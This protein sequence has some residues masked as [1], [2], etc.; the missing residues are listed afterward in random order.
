MTHETTLTVPLLLQWCTKNHQNIKQAQMGGKKRC[1]SGKYHFTG[2]KLSQK[3]WSLVCVCGHVC[4]C[5]PNGCATKKSK[6]AS[7]QRLLI[8]IW[9][10]GVYSWLPWEDRNYAL[11]EGRWQS[12]KKRDRWGGRVRA[13]ETFNE[14]KR[15]LERENQKVR[16]LQGQEME[17]GNTKTQKE[18]FYSRTGVCVCA[19]QSM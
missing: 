2:T 19:H 1:T 17:Q 15:N 18:K 9:V 13:R 8:S 3:D 6:R 4:E 7:T 5:V 16:I 12:E 11:P 10:E 14:E